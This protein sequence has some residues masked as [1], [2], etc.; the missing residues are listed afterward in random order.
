LLSAVTA[1]SVAA[2]LNAQ[3]ATG[4]PDS[5]CT[6]YPDGRVECKI[7]RGS[8]RG[9][10]ALHNR[11]FRMDSAMAKRAALGIELRAT[12]TRRDTLGVFVEAVTPK[13]PAESAGIIEGDR[14]SAING[15]DLRTAAGDVDDSYTNGLAAHRL[16]REVQ[17]LTPGSRVTLR[18]YSGGRFRDVQVTAGK[19]S[20]LMRLG[21][22]FNFRIPGPGGMMEFNGSGGAM[23]FGPEMPM[24]RK[25]IEPLLRERLNNLPS[26]IQLRSPMRFRT[27]APTTA[28]IETG[29]LNNE[30]DGFMLDMDDE[31]FDI[32]NV[33]EL[34]PPAVIR[35]LAASAIRDAQS[36]L[37]QLAADGVA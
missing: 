20:D 22:R 10:S 6:N 23:M 29:D 3:V 12:G 26:K 15:V 21:G 19:A 31:L 14:I 25:K 8:A 33:I 11:I 37:K 4:K 5:T 13:G 2:T 18:V 34:V 35:D 32:E 24:L 16:T 30:E 1:T 9:D 7:T 28:F 27:L 17:K 36:A